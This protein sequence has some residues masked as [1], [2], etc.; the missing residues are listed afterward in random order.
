[1]ACGLRAIGP[2]PAWPVCN[3]Y[4][5]TIECVHAFHRGGVPGPR[6]NPGGKTGVASGVAP[7]RSDGGTA[8]LAR[9]VAALRA[10]TERRFQEMA[11]TVDKLARE[12]AR[13]G[14]GMGDLQ[15][16]QRRL[17]IDVADLE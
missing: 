11:A 13:L 4:R 12:V 17:V 5:E 10:E 8:V 3:R 9:A 16:T 15:K 7:S 14:I 6:Q 1:M 2:P